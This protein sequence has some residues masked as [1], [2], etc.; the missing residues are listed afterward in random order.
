M[1][2]AHCGGRYADITYAH[3]GRLEAA[4]EVHSSWGTFEWL[5]AMRSTRTTA[6]ASSATPM[7]TRAGRARAFPGASFF[8]AYGGSDLLSG[9][10][11][12]RATAS[13]KRCGHAGTTARRAT[14]CCS[15]CRRP[16]AGG[17]SASTGIQLLFDDARVRA[18]RSLLMGDIAQV[19]G[20]DSDAIG[21]GGRFGTD[22]EDRCVRWHRTDPYASA[23]MERRCSVGGC[24]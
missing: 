24:D 21:R 12:S 9:R 10:R 1:C 14:A 11:S 7:G 18:G 16:P 13:S 15:T 3:D 20:E 5:L 6:S 4:V 2:W 19:T 22:R 23:L 8:G 17:A